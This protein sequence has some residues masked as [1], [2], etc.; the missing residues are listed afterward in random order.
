[1]NKPL[2]AQ[3]SAS[4]SE[5]LHTVGWLTH[6]PPWEQWA[7]QNYDLHTFPSSGSCWGQAL[8][9][10]GLTYIRW[11]K[12]LCLPSK[13]WNLRSSLESGLGLWL[14]RLTEKV[15]SWDLWAQA[16]R[17]PSQFQLLHLETQG[18]HKKSEIEREATWGHAEGERQHGARGLMEEYQGPSPN[19]LQVHE[20]HWD[21]GEEP[22]AESQ[23]THGF[24]R[25]H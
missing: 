11:P 15:K 20:K 21:T 25:Y 6:L 19:C 24:V 22:A 4:Y 13:R 9:L 16:P 18:W 8:E 5:G 10:G 14:L 23:E 7:I 2:K 12:H 1:M 3:E 17:K